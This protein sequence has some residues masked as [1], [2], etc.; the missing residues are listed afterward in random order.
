MLGAG[1][2]HDEVEDDAH[3]PL[4]GLGDESIEVGLRAVL[5]LDGFVVRSVVA[6]IARRL[7]DRREPE[8]VDAEVVPEVVEL[9]GDAVQVSDAVAVRVREAAHEDLVK[10]RAAHPLV[11]PRLH[12]QDGA[13][14]GGD[15]RGGAGD[16]E[17]NDGKPPD[18]HDIMDGK[19]RTMRKMLALGAILLAASCVKGPEATSTSATTS[20]AA[21]GGPVRIGFSMDTLKEERWQRDKQAIA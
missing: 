16:E 1:V 19:E 6:V 17:E 13:P 2:V 9:R 21:H 12:R 14:A 10:D 20:A 3:S 7:E 4:V 5:L 15:R 18:H 11:V 8:R